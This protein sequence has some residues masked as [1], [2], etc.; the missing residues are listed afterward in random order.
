MEELLPLLARCTG[1]DTYQIVLSAPTDPEEAEKR[2]TLIRRGLAWQIERF[3]N[4]QAFHENV[5]QDELI[6]LLLQLMER[7][8]QLNAWDAE[9]QYS[10]K[11]TKKGKPLF[12]RQ[13]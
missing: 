11:L 7:F 4:H 2:I 3:R 10:L 8:K 9:Y 13:R 6:P 5:E 12:N 1:P